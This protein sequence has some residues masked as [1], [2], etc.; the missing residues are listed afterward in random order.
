MLRY[1]YKYI[2]PIERLEDVRRL[3]AP[4]MVHDSFAA[5][6]GGDYTVRSIYFDTPDFECY[7]TKLAGIKHRK[8]LRI[9]GYNEEA[10]DNEIF[11]EI[12]KKYEDPILKY[13][14]SLSFDR[15]EAVF[16]GDALEALEPDQREGRSGES[17]KRFL[18]HIYSGQMRPVV[19]VV[20]EREAY[21]SRFPNPQN[22]LRITLDKNLRSL[23]FPSLEGLYKELEPVPVLTGHF[24]M[25]IKFNQEMPA[26]AAQMTGKLGVKRR[27][28]S[29]YCLCIEAHPDITPQNRFDLIKQAKPFR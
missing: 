6:N 17:M 29:K 23:A 13:R 15:L 26:W 25:E 9:R 18:Y 28:A 8:K 3:L 27:A 21:E 22:N 7:T 1:E 16:N 11:L 24:I 14:T 10:P 4:Y 20:Y 12:K 19:T 5:K 2:L